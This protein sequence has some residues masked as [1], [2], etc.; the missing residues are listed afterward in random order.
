[1]KNLY[2]QRG[3]T[4]IMIVVI[5]VMLAFFATAAIKVMPLY[6][7][8]FTIAGVVKSVAEDPELREKSKSEIRSLVERRLTINGLDQYAKH[9]KVRPGEGVMIL[10]L[11]YERRENFYGNLDV[12]AVFENRAE[13]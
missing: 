13:F 11:N 8:N 6:L 3:M 10:E 9:T 2:K 7:D 1:M 5:L 4:N 12:V